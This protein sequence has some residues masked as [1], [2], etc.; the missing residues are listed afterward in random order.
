MPRSTPRTPNTLLREAI[1]ESGLTYAALARAVRAVAAAAG[2]TGVRTNASAIAHWVAGTQPEPDT[3][4]YVTEALAQRTGRRLTAAG[5]GL[6]VLQDAG[7]DPAGLGLSLGPVPVETIAAMGRA[8]IERRR[9]LTTAVYSVAAAALPLGAAGEHQARAEAVRTGATA[10][11]AEID[12]VRSMTAAFTEIDERYGGQHGRS[13]VL[14]YLT[15]DVTD[16]CRASFR[17]PGQRAQ[18][19]TAAAGLAYL[20]GW[21]AFDAGEQG[22]AQRWYLQ[23]YALTREADDG[24]HQ[25]FALRILA[26]HGMDTGHQEHT[27]DLADAALAQVRGRVPAPTESLFVVCKARAL[28]GAG[29]SRQAL[30]VAGR[31]RA[32][33][34]S[35]AGTAGWDAMWGAAA[36]AVDSHTAAILTR[37]G[38]HAGAETH[39]ASAARH[40]RGTEHQRIA[41]LS[42]AAEGRA[43]CAQGHVE[44]ACATWGRAL[45]GMTGIRST[46]TRQAVI[47]LRADLA[48]L[49]RRGARSAQALDDRARVWL[50]ETA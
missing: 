35:G 40:Y 25:G 1:A 16:L 9:F 50:H 8:D 47:T 48:R 15:T 4:R 12:A 27:V 34:E 43:Q 41:A 13:A 44:R 33:A 45:D 31:A 2:D 38:D 11:Q 22:L 42:T 19:L 18:M 26:H 17:T 21:K 14:Q 23:S 7:A 28:S 29:S 20:A 49:R 46:R 6:A 37:L 24:P 3:A 5:L 30:A 10:G 39:W 36:A 32:L